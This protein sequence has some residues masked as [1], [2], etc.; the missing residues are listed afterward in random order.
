[1]LKVQPQNINGKKLTCENNIMVEA[2][3]SAGF[4][5]ATSFFPQIH[6]QFSWVFK[7]RLEV[8][9]SVLVMEGLV[10][11][12]LCVTLTVQMLYFVLISE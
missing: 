6:L 3:G 11:F 12:S 1:V 10:C 9:S 4:H 5:L 7:L 2:C 8:V